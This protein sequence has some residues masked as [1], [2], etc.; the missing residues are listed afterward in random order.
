MTSVGDTISKTTRKLEELLLQIDDIKEKLNSAEYLAI[1]NNISIIYQNID[2]LKDY[3]YINEENFERNEN[4]E[5]ISMFDD[6]NILTS[7]NYGDENIDIDAE[8]DEINAQNRQLFETYM[9]ASWQHAIVVYANVHHM[10]PE[11]V[12]S[13]FNLTREIDPATIYNCS[14]VETE[15][16][17]ICA[18]NILNCRNIQHLLLKHPLLITVILSD[19]YDSNVLVEEYNKFFRLDLTSYLN[20]DG[21]LPTTEENATIEYGRL[22]SHLHIFIKFCNELHDN[23]IIIHI[24]I[25]LMI[26]LLFN[27]YYLIKERPMYINLLK[28]FSDKLNEFFDIETLEGDALEKHKKKITKFEDTLEMFNLPRDTL[29]CCTNVLAEIAEYGIIA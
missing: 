20:D 16:V 17:H 18:G 7:V 13:K 1:V 14:C 26:Q 12:D 4:D 19:K 28:T 29:K 3:A 10:P 9:F 22:N 21:Q 27:K 6:E 8:I 5:D 2:N 25:M 24:C 11:F 15:S 23:G